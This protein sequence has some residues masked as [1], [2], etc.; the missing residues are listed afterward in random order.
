M[1][2]DDRS[3]R[4]Y[5]DGQSKNLKK[6]RGIRNIYYLIVSSRFSDEFEDLIRSLKM[7]T[8]VNEVCLVEATALVAIVDQKLRSPLTV[9]LGSDG[10]QQLFSSS[11]KITLNDVVESLS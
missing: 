6:T 7:K 10:I 3:I 11:G 9:G 2:T 4:E 8:H 1:G 5:I